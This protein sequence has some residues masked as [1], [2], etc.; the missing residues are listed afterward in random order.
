M[1]Y[2]FFFIVVN[3]TDHLFLYE[4]AFHLLTFHISANHLWRP[5]NNP[6]KMIK[7]NSFLTPSFYITLLF[8]LYINF[9]ILNKTKRCV[10]KYHLRLQIQFKSLLFSFLS[11]S[12][13]N[14]T[15][16]K[17]PL[18]LFV[19]HSYSWFQCVTSRLF[20][21]PTDSN[22]WRHVCFF[23][24]LISLGDVTFVINQISLQHFEITKLKC[25]LV[26]PYIYL[27]S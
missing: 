27:S 11:N 1:M 21:C 10:R 23:A 12:L 16:D 5:E 15:V 8:R 18:S 24:R 13:L 9:N 14:Q 22:V 2:R 26:H 4:L 25:F 3:K 19:H 17:Y 7:N 6:Q 20:L